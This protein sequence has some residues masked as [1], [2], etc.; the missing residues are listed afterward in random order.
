MAYYKYFADDGRELLG[1]LY[2]WFEEAYNLYWPTCPHSNQLPKRD[3]TRCNGYFACYK[4]PARWWNIRIPAATLLQTLKFMNS[5]MRDK[6]RLLDDAE[7]L[8]FISPT[9]HLKK[10]GTTSMYFRSVRCGNL[11]RKRPPPNPRARAALGGGCQWR[12]SLRPRR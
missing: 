2:T 10:A 12:S 6:E 11:Q 4:R 5:I 9:Q 7:P 1:K 8:R 3:V